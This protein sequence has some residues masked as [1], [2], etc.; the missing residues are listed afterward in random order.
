MSSG[1]EKK[2]N[3]P[4][5]TSSITLFKGPPSRLLPFG[6]QFSIIFVILLFFILVTC[7]SQFLLYRVT[8][9]N[10]TSFEWVVLRT[11][12]RR[13]NCA[14]VWFQQ[15][16]ATAHAANESM[17][18]VRYMFPGHLISRFGDVPWPPRSPDLSTCDF[19]WG[20]VT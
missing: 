18:I 2:R 5:S 20:G 6:L 13:I 8:H 10:L 14:S 4:V 1:K 15:D 16:G 9:G 7:R 11:R 12:R 19:F 17:T 3:I